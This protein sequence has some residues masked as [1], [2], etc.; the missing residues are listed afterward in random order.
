VIQHDVWKVATARGRSY[1]VVT[2]P[3]GSYDAERY[4]E[5]EVLHM[6]IG[7]NVIVSIRDTGSSP[8]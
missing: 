3:T 8:Y 4:D 2:Q 6:H 5:N 1:W 7:R